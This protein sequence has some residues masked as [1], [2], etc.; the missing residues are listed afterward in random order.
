MQFF[1]AIVQTGCSEINICS[2]IYFILFCKWQMQNRCCKNFIYF[3][4]SIYCTFIDRIVVAKVPLVASVC[5]CPLS[6]GTLL[7]E[8]FDLDFWHEGRP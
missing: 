6:V 1:L 8:P 5:V 7:F 2:S 4:C 3:C